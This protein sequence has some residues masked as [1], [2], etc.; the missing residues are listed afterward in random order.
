MI[1][2]LNPNDLKQLRSAR[3]NVRLRRYMLSTIA[4]IIVIAGAYGVGYKLAHDGYVAAEEQNNLAKKDLEKYSDV[5]KQANEYR[6]NL[7]TAKKILGGEIIFSEFIT[8]V[9]KVMPPNT[10]LSDLTMTTKKPTTRSSTVKAGSTTLRA[11]VKTH[12]DAINLRNKLEES[13][14]FS[15]VSIANTV[16]NESS[17]S[18]N[19]TNDDFLVRNYP[20]QVTYSLVIDQLGVTK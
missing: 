8:S 9:A 19:S 12:D 1:N 16:V 17:E 15:S 4:A 13:D 20:I 10:V 2:L 11:R 7:D 5:L 14:I 3:V 6:S 18:S